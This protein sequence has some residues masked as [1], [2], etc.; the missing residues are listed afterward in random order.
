MYALQERVRQMC[1][2]APAQIA[3]GKVSVYHGGGMFAASGTVQNVEPP[4]VEEDGRV[5]KA[6]Y[7]QIR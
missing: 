4:A 3:G 6:R 5:G 2:T 1:G 7:S